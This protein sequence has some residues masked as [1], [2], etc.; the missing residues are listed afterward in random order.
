MNRKTRRLPREVPRLSLMSNLRE[1]AT[2]T[3][4]FLR[5]ILETL[6]GM[7]T[8][9][10]KD[11]PSDVQGGDAGSPGLEGDGWSG[12]GHVHHLNTTGLPGDVTTGAAVQGAGP[13]VSLSGHKHHIDP[14]LLG[15]G[16]VPGFPGEQGDPG[17][18]GIPG[19]PG[20]TGS[21]GSA[22]AGG[23]L[24]PPGIEGDQG[25]PGDP[26]PPGPQGPAGLDGI[27]GAMGA[28]GYGEQG[29]PGDPG[30]P[31][32]TGAQGASGIPGFADDGEVGAPGQPGPPGADGATGQIGPPGPQGDE[33]EQGSPGP[34]G[35]STAPTGT[36]F[37]HITSGL[38]DPGASPLV[39]IPHVL[40][41]DYTL[42]DGV[43][44]YIPRYFEIAA[45]VTFTI[46]ANSD[47]EIG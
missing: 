28:A 40:T 36:G 9:F 17:D 31:G 4:A 24:G 38:Q 5:D 12:G 32:P 8:G 20:P 6:T 34:P 33:G 27:A 26:G 41:A 39:Y 23:A 47:L 46:G 2:K 14:S 22:G 44:A 13:G 45:G 42:P 1:V 16:G 11:Q 21:A 3:E 18:A 43:G 10:S 7:P 35:Q 25:D 37:V 29:D 15:M 30:P 19:P